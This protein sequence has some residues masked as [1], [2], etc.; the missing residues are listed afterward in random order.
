LTPKILKEH[1][2]KHTGIYTYVFSIILYK[3]FLIIHQQISIHISIKF[4][5]KQLKNAKKKQMH[6]C[7]GTA[8]LALLSV[9][10]S[11]SEAI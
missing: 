8:K 2:K 6:R 1:K 4:Y 5:K 11:L 10:N 7:M 3:Y 9:T